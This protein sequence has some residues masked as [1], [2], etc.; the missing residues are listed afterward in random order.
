MKK[1]MYLFVA[2][3]MFAFTACGGGDTATEEAVPTAEE[4]VE[5]APEE[6]IEDTT[7]VSEE[8]EA[9]EETAAEEAHSHDHE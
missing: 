6:V 2:A 4:T 9:T 1:L 3:I 8:A 7:A 5:T